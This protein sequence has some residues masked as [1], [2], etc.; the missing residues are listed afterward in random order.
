M[1]WGDCMTK[2]INY[3]NEYLK[4]KFGERT[5]KICVDGGFTCPNRDGTKGNN[6]CIFCSERG[7]GEHLSQELSITKQIENSFKAIKIQRA[8][9]F[10]IY[11]QNYSNTYDNLEN[12]KR[13]YDEAIRAFN[14]CSSTYENDYLYSKSLSTDVFNNSNKKRL[15]GLQVATRP[16]LI[17]E[18][19]A[20]LLSEY[21][22]DLYVAVELGLQTINDDEYNFL[23]RCYTS[24]D[25]SKAVKLLRKYNIDIVAH[26]MVGLPTKIG[27]ETHEDIVNTIGFINSQ[28]IQG[29]KIHSCYVVEN[30]LL[31][32]LYKEKRYVPISLETYL[33]ELAFIITHVSPKLV[34][35]R[36]SGDAPKNIL[37]APEW[38][39]HK[40]LVLN[41]IYK[42]LNEQDLWQGKYYSN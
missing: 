13:K 7:S 40:K 8:N 18:E 32:Q 22:N 38:N 9:N 35:H 3:I 36:I 31:E 5:L 25:F 16:D 2:R 34:I 1:I 42:L 41:G 4:E 12:L 14:E 26:M 19:I 11:F 10:I 17:T 6:G 28:D 20:K 33:N 23:N 21:N 30:T 37:V 27:V 29:L 39:S 24:K 15:V